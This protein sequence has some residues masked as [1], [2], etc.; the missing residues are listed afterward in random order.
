MDKSAKLEY[1]PQTRGLAGQWGKWKGAACLA[2]E[3]DGKVVCRGYCASHYNKKKWADGSRPP[4][5]NPES[6]R[7]AHIKHRYGLT[8]EE[9]AGLV[10]AQGGKCAV[11]GEHPARTPGH[12]NDGLCVDHCHDS[13]KVR[14][15]LCNNCNIAIGHTRTERVALAM[16]EYF[17]IHDGP[18][19]Q[20]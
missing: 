3:C 16:A 14:G 15:L 4:S 13:S 18:G 6:R 17:R 5:A 8:A 7:A 20:Y 1:D 19:R 2:G 10:A 11:C 9:H 12:W